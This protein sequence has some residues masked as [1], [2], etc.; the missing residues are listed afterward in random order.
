MS[1]R[2]VCRT[3]VLETALAASIPV[4]VQVLPASPRVPSQLILHGAQR[5]ALARSP[6]L[7]RARAEIKA[8][9]SRAEYRSRLPD[10]ELTLGAQ[11]LP[12]DTLA[13]NQSGMSTLGFGLSQKFPP[14]GKL[15]L[16]HRQ[17]ERDADALRYRRMNLKTAIVRAVR[18]AWLAL[19]YDG[20]EIEV[21]HEN[22]VLYHRIDEAALARHRSLLLRPS[23]R[24][25]GAP[26]YDK[27]D[28]VDVFERAA[29]HRVD[30]GMPVTRKHSFDGIQTCQERRKP[31]AQ[32]LVYAPAARDARQDI[33]VPLAHS[34]RAGADTLVDVPHYFSHLFRGSLA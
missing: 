4:W 16:I 29:A 26:A 17:L 3:G 22:Q 21:L 31:L 15:G 12:A 8:G 23:G 19:Y 27:T 14:P 13:L 30:P 9:G 5:L 28:R 1:C 32:P 34:V 25:L 6:V 2:Y 24:A 10:P 20:R 18:S 11:N 33:Q 7:A